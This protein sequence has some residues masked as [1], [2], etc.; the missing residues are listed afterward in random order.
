MF[1]LTFY[2]MKN[3]QIYDGFHKNIKL[4]YLQLF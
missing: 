4:N 1:I 2:S 3:I